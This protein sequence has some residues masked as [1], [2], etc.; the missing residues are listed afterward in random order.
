MKVHVLADRCPWC[1]DL[2]RVELT[3]DAAWASDVE[4]PHCH[5]R[6]SIEFDRASLVVK[7]DRSLFADIQLSVP[8]R[9]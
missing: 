2:F 4:C 3:D 6:V 8:L 5:F 7:R 9:H 1:K